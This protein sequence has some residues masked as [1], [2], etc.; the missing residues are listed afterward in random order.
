MKKTVCFVLLL[1]LSLGLFAGA[2]GFSL[3]AGAINESLQS[4]LL[5]A[6]Y[7]PANR[8]IGTGSGFVAFSD[9]YIVTNCHVIRD[10]GFVIAYSDEGKTFTLDTVLCTDYQNDIAILCFNENSGL[11]PLAISETPVERGEAVVAIGSP[12]G[13]RNTVSLGV[14]ASTGVDAESGYI[15]FTAPISS[16]SSGGA[17]FNDAGEVIGITSAT[18]ADEGAQNLNFAVDISLAAQLYRDYAD[19]QPVPI[20]EWK[21]VSATDPTDPLPEE[22]EFTLRDYAGFAISEVYLYPMGSDGW[23]RARNNGWLYRDQSMVIPVSDE[24]AVSDKRFTLN[25]CFYL[26]GRNYYIEYPGIRMPEILGRTLTLYMEEGNVLRI[27]IE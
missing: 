2:E 5:L 17:L 3:D 9:Q 15:N 13:F 4:V 18:H 10:A 23:G 12:Q 16:G 26:S 19:K 22:R 24:E 11:K 27:E 8:L 21:S 1:C 20:S 25:L 7:D 14:A 6:V